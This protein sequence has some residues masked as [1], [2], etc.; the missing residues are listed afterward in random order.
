MQDDD[1]NVDAA[2]ALKTPQDSRDL[3]A[4]WASDYD[5]DFAVSQAYQLPDETIA[6][7]VAA[8]GRGP[9][10]DIG[11]GTGLC[12]TVLAT[13]G[14]GPVDGIDISPQMLEVARDKNVYRD[15]FEADLY[16]GVPLPDGGYGGVVSAGTFTNGH[17]GPEVIGG[18]LRLAQPDAVFALAINAQHYDALGFGAAL[19]ALEGQIRDL[20]LPEVRIY[21]PGATGD[22]KD[23]LARIAVFRKA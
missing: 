23:D 19:A 21:G 10:L 8:G 4:R 15:L 5:T 9:V 22:H 16:A 12:G 17:V 11:A 7:F 3:Y 2:Y 1:P 13:A 18:I 20:R 6:A 14:V